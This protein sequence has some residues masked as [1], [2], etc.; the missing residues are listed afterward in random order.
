MNEYF[1]ECDEC[2]MIESEQDMDRDADYGSC[3][4]FYCDCGR[5]LDYFEWLYRVNDETGEKTWRT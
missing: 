4:D 2:G 5:R 3:S 1:Y